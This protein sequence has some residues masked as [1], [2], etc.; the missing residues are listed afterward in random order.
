MKKILLTWANWMLASDFIK[1]CSNNFEIFA[2]DKQNLDITNVASIE[3]IIKEIKP[4]IILNCAAYT[5]VDDAEDIWKKLNFDINTIWTYNLSK[6]TN[7]YNLDFITISTDYVFDWE[8]E[9]WYDENDVCNP[10]NEYWMSK[11]L[12]EKLSLN[13]NKNTIIIRTSWLYWWW[14]QFKNFVNTIIKLAETRNELKIINDQF[15]IPTYTKDLSV[16]ISE[17]IKN[18]TNFRWKI[19]HF[20]NSDENNWTTWFNFAIEIKK[21]N[22]FK[23][24]IFPC[25]SD[26]YVT[27]AKR[28]RYSLMK[29]NS[30]IKL[31]N[32]KEWINDYLNNI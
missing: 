20:S 13:E 30:I 9:N 15:W 5:A 29:N 17:V 24:E 26:D 2:F 28:P 18:I 7:K 6:I 16:A 21:L 12:G 31:R 4:D 14:K 11:Y 19:L 32:W 27:K 8:K 3:K 25:T 23:T 22:K 10:I 1:Y